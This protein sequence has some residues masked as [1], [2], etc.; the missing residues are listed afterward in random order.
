VTFIYL[1]ASLFN[2]KLN[3]RQPIFVFSI[4]PVFI[5]LQIL[6]VLTVD[7]IQKIRSERII[8]KIEKDKTVKGELPREITYP[9]GIEYIRTID[10][11]NFEISYSRGFFGY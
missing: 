3:K 11:E 10:N 4:L 8:V 2:K 1:I 6:S 5:F 7:K 9:F